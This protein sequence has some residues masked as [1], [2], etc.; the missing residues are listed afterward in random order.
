MLRFEGKCID[1]FKKVGAHE[2]LSCIILNPTLYAPHY[3]PCSVTDEL[4][5][6]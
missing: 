4:L 6:T 3:E 1:G 5:Q 2:G